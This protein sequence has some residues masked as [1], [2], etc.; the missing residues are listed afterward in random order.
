MVM[1]DSD[2]SQKVVVSLTNRTIIRTILWVVVAVIAY[3]MF[4]RIG[5]ILTLIFAAFF[6]ALALNPVVSWTTR[7]LK[8]DSR[9]RATAAAYAMVITVL[10][11]LFAL[12]TP[13]LIS[14]TRD[15]INEV[16][17][18]VDDFQKQ[19]SGL[20]RTAKRY[21]LDEKISTS[22]RD[23]AKNY[24][25]FGS[26]ILD[27]GKRVATIIA[28][29]VAVIVMA[30][31]ML[32]EGPYWMALIWGFVPKK[33]RAH[34]K[35]LAHEMYKGVSGFVNG[36]VI[37]SLV[38]GM[39][40]FIALTIASHILGVSVNAAALAGIVAV[41]GLIPLF[42]NPISSTIVLLFCLLS[43]VHLAI[44]MAIYFV[45]YYFVENHT[46][47]PYI[48]SRLNK[49]TALSVFVS[50]LLGIG[51][52][53]FMG[54]IVAIPAASATK[55]LVEDYFKRSSGSNPPSTKGIDTSSAV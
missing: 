42:G 52:A 7:R 19:D 15:F 28:E 2:K 14:Q 26:T 50:A 36:Q 43:S 17:K 22:A 27:T 34:V 20:A 33:D 54:A 31:M 23:F 40:T 46:F 10:I 29:S 39:F 4:F 11:A 18:L 47:Q 45:V 38:A 5:H 3:K 51:L 16:P 48:Q 53:G 55:V 44:I 49:L 41:F 12:V 25:N 24:G 37:I 13:P 6:L 30:F 21:N 9:A 8:I 1:S 35:G 32:V